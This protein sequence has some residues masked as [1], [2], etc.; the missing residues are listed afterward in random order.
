MSEPVKVR[1]SAAEVR[2]RCGGISEMTLWRW[3]E[4]PTMEFP[5][6]IYIVRRRFWDADE[7]EDFLSRQPSS[8][9]AA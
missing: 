7:V 5:K 3:L 1:I 9:S 4:H 6:P 8:K 2:K